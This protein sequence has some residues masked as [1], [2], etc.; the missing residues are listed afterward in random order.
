MDLGLDGRVYLVTG[1]TA[2]RLIAAAR[3]RRVWPEW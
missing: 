2:G 1:G 3:E